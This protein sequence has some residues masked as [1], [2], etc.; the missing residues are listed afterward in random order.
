MGGVADQLARISSLTSKIAALEHDRELAVSSALAGG[1]SWPQIARSL[2]C[3]TQA[4]H[5]R[6]RW[7][8]HNDKTGEVWYERPLTGRKARTS[9]T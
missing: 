6:F 4:A 8:H 2:G 7:I 5:K 3:S 1:A 9:A